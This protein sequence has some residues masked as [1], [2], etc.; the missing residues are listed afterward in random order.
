MLKTV[1]KT[2][3]ALRIF[4]LCYIIIAFL[5][6]L[7][8]NPIDIGKFIGAGMGSAVGMSLSVPENPFNRLAFQL[9]EKEESLNQR[10]VELNEREQALKS[11][12][13]QNIIF[14]ILAAGIGVLFVLVM[15]NYYFDYKRRKKEAENKK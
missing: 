6:V 7:G 11:S 8:V 15:L 13:G 1:V 3:H 12:G 10:E 4:F 5:F 14:I 9:K 2:I